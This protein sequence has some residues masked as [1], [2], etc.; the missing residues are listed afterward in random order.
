M[1]VDID[2]LAVNL[3]HLNDPMFGHDIYDWPFV[4]LHGQ[5]EQHNATYADA[6][7]F[8][9]AAPDIFKADRPMPVEPGEYQAKLYGRDVIVVLAERFNGRLL[10]G[11]AACADDANA[12]V[13]VRDVQSWR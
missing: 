8:E 3:H 6:C 10:G 5:A 9:W 11:R 7:G 13:H 12:L 2:H 1:T 4:Y